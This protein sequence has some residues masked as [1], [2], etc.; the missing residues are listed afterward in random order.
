MGSQSGIVPILQ[1]S[2]IRSEKCLREPFWTNW[3]YRNIDRCD[4]VIV[5]HFGYSFQDGIEADRVLNK[6]DQSAA[7]ASCTP[8]DERRVAT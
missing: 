7:G 1:Q 8:Q 6:R 4:E 3:E 5:F 2:K